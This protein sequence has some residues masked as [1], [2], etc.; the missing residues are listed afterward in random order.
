MKKLLL[1]VLLC[2]ELS[3]YSQNLAPI[4]IDDTLIIDYY[5]SDLFRITASHFTLN[6]S[7]PNGDPLMVINAQFT[8]SNTTSNII[9]INNIFVTV[10]Y[11]AASGFSGYD[12]IEYVVS[13]GQNPALTDTAFFY[14]KVKEPVHAFLDANNIKARVDIYSLFSTRNYESGFEAPAGH[15]K[16]TIFRSNLWVTGESSQQVYSTSRRYKGSDNS[17]HYPSNSGPIS[18]SSTTPFLLDN[19]WDQVFKVYQDNIDFHLAHYTDPN[20][21]V[22]PNI[23]NWPAHG[24]IING[25]AANLAPFFDQNGDGVY[26]PLEGDYPQIKGDQAIYFIYNDVYTE[27]GINPMHIEIHGMAY[28]FQCTDSAIQNS[29]F[30]DFKIYNRSNR[31][32]YN[33]H[34]GYW[35]D[36]ALGS[37]LDDYIQ[38]DVNRGLY[39]A[40][41]GNDYDDDDGYFFGYGDH[42]SAQSVILLR[43]PKQDADGLD[44]NFGI[45][46]NESINGSGFGDG[47]A[48]NEYWG[49]N[50]FIKNQFSSG[51]QGDPI[52][53]NDFHN[54]LRGFWKDGTSV[55]HG[56][57][58]NIPS[59][60][61]FPDNSDSHHFG[62]HGIIAPLWNETTA[63]NTPGNRK[64]IGSTGPVTLAPGDA[65]ELTYAF[66]FGRD[67]VN[68]GA[69]A[70]VI[71]M[72]KRA[73]S[74]RNYYEQGILDPCGFPLSSP[75]INKPKN[76]FKLYPNPS[77]NRVKIEQ[78]GNEPITIRLMDISGK[79]LMI[80]KSSLAIS[81]LE[82]EPFP[83]GI[84]FVEIQ[85]S[86]TRELLKVIKQ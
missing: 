68:T 24:N 10:D 53:P 36:F 29:I 46:T 65:M 62:T 25:E 69:Q 6:D 54:Y 13:D 86:D 71:N 14:I 49:L 28:A 73:D 80:K 3:G 67:Y 21:N 16:S 56:N 8:S 57:D 4:A 2:L 9:I 12:T 45:N 48:D 63:S 37:P 70:G 50:G 33:T 19:K 15:G 78:S 40:Y 11:I 34:I 7:D 1:F 41:N 61:M 55:Y 18:N 26:T 59:K 82:L 74:I 79:I 17:K 27:Q 60:F 76:L 32:Y 22:V 5:D 23:A 75:T 85:N 51:I 72:L 43:G 42:P 58:P 39:F 35:C 77:Q 66:V 81:T 84:Y 20:Y 44:N 30:V 64:G 38:C 31:I 47:I 83:L 52:S